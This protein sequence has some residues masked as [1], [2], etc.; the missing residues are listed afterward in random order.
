MEVD[1]TKMTVNFLENDAKECSVIVEYDVSGLD[2]YAWAQGKDKSVLFSRRYAY[3]KD[4]PWRAAMH[5][6][7][8]MMDIIDDLERTRIRQKIEK[9]GSKHIGLCMRMKDHPPCD[10]GNCPIIEKMKKE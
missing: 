4:E 7:S 5:V 3:P 10:P 2:G 8:A 1:L 9:C 6:S